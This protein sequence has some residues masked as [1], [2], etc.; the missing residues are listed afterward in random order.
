VQVQRFVGQW[1][2][3]FDHQRD[4]RRNIIKLIKVFL[5]DDIL[6][7][8]DSSFSRYKHIKSFVCCF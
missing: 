2:S 3:W 4:K 5:I 1:Y 6:D 8:D 7:F